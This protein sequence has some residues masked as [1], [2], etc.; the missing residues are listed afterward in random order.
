LLAGFYG[1]VLPEELMK[2]VVASEAFQAV[3]AA[4]G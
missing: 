2:A 3:E 4:P 1:Y